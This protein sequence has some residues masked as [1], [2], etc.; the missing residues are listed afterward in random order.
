M[1][2]DILIASVQKAVIQ[3]SSGTQ[4][5][6][7]FSHPEVIAG[8]IS[9][10]Y[11]QILKTFYSS[12]INLMDAEL[13]YYSKK[14]RLAIQKDS[15]EVYYVTLP[16]RPVGLKSNLGLRYV[17]PAKGKISFVRANDVEMESIRNLEVSKCSNHVFYYMDIGRI[18][19]ELTTAEH[20]LIEEV[21]VKLLPVFTDFDD[22]DEIDFPTGGKAATDMVLETMGFRPTDL[23]NDD[24]K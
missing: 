24:V 9:K 7:K 4:D 1:R 12:N 11:D 6:L 8:E 17:R 5:S 15:D 13:D 23:T 19:L 18:S 14:Y 22:D 16:V 10:A 21:D 20:R 3:Q 2:K